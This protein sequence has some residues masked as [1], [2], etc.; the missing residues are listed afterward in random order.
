MKAVLKKVKQNKG[1]TLSELLAATVILLLVSGMLT[2]CILLGM[3][4]LDK[5]TQESEAQMLCTML[6]TAVQDELSFATSPELTDTADGKFLS[7]E[8]EGKRIGFYVTS[9]DTHYTITDEETHAKDHLGKLCYASKDEHE[10]IKTDTIENLVSDGAYDVKTASYGSL[11]ASMQIKEYTGGYEVI[12]NVYNGLTTPELLATKDFYVGLVATDAGATIIPDMK[13]YTVTFDANGGYFDTEGHPSQIVYSGKMKGDLVDV[14]NAP[15]KSGAEFLRWSPKI[16]D[17]AEKVKVTGDVTYMAVWPGSGTGTA[18]FYG[19]YVD[20]NPNAPGENHIANALSVAAGN[21][22]GGMKNGVTIYWPGKQ[23]DYDDGIVAKVYASGI[24]PEG[25]VFD[26]WEDWTDPN[27]RKVYYFKN[28]DYGDIWTSEGKDAVF[29]VHYSPVYKFKFYNGSLDTPLVEKTATYDSVA[30]EYVFESA[31]GDLNLKHWD[32]NNNWKF[33][34]WYLDRNN[35]KVTITDGKRIPARDVAKALN[36][37]SNRTVNLYAGYTNE[38]TLYYK[39]DRLE[40]GKTMLLVGGNNGDSVVTQ[41]EK[42]MIRLNHS[43]FDDGI[44]E[45][46]VTTYGN[47]Y[48]NYILVGPGSKGEFKVSTGSYTKRYYI[49]MKIGSTTT[50]LDL[51][52]DYLFF[53]WKWHV[54]LKDTA[55]KNTRQ[56]YYDDTHYYLDGYWRRLLDQKEQDI[57]FDG[58]TFEVCEKDEYPDNGQMHI[59]EYYEKGKALSFN[60]IE[61]PKLN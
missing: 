22:I 46:D 17:G 58:G 56:W 14:P 36:N 12:I 11:Q 42:V 43:V 47:K 61:P 60:G 37:S 30:Q 52:Y 51:I 9:R 8:K 23:K 27:N 48:D 33:D 44:T 41:T 16:P 50:Y 25:C 20:Y 4:Q 13:K 6:S 38:K 54:R 15:T 32:E 26:G 31:L 35:P 1:F 28:G 2:T 49:S 18:R 34:G 59:Y 40:N 7:F 55:T 5:E 21:I 19:R 53:N 3:K 57:Y 45:E 39:M 29:V 24:I 10:N